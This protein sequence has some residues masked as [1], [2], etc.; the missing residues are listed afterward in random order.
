MGL[1]HTAWLEARK[2]I[3]ELLSKDCAI[4]RDDSQ[5]RSKAFVNQ[6]DATLYL[7][8]EIG[9]Y[10]D[11]YSSIHVDF[12]L[13]IISISFNFSTQQTSEFCSVEKRIHYC[14]TGN[15]FQLV[16]MD[17]LQAWLCLERRFVVHT[18]N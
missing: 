12:S 13:N 18:D 9:D 3:R 10:T 5:L 7:P 2:T 4:L 1:K 16:I 8:A 14:Q 17:V 11:F 6:V 15:I